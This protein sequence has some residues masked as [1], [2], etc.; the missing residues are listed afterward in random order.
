MGFLDRYRRNRAAKRY[1]RELP[2]QLVRSFGGGSK[3]YTAAQIRKAVEK[4]RLDDRFIAFGYAAFL[5]E[6]AFGNTVAEMPIAISYDEARAL[7]AG[8][9]PSVPY[10]VSGS[11]AFD[12]MAGSVQGDGGGHGGD[13]SGH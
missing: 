1:A 7:L 2:R 11:A 3:H 5:P 6:E 13:G 10:S 9:K 12:S 4:L 8:F